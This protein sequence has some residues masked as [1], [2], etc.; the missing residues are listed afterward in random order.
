MKKEGQ[1]L[2]RIKENV[3]CV[4]CN[5]IG[6]VQFYGT[7]YPKGMGETNIESYKKYEN[8]P[9]LSKAAGFGGTRPYKCLNCGNVG[10]IDIGGLE[11][12]DMAF[13]TITEEC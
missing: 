7:Y 5:S 11:G 8:T 10:L 6:A 9:Y 4:K 13:K 3:K 2:F 1:E 12:Y